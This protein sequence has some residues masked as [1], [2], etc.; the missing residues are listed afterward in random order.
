VSELDERARQVI[1]S[2]RYL[3]LGTTE[4]DGR[5]RLSPVY[6]I[7]TDYRDFWWVSA[8]DAHHSA[9]LAARP[10]V[11]LVIYDSTVPVGAGRAVYVTAEA[12]EMP[13]A[14]F[15]SARGDGVS[16]PAEELTGDADLRLYRARASAHEIHVAGG[17][18]AY[19]SGIDRRVPVTP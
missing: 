11:A 1:D 16:I 19:G 15:E 7:H 10:A 3:V 6:F 17:D 2:N 12:A 14:A 8:P 18:P 9:N 13:P 4:P 5:P